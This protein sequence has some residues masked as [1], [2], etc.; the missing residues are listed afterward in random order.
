[1]G[2]SSPLRRKEPAMVLLLRFTGHT[3]IAAGSPD[4]QL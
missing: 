1:M 4:I 3:K 2:S